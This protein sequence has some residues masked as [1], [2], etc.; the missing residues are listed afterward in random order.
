MNESNERRSA[1]VNKALTCMQILA[2]LDAAGPVR[3]PMTEDEFNQDDIYVYIA[4]TKELIT[5]WPSSSHKVQYA[6]RFGFR[7]DAGQTWAK[8]M[9]AK[10]LGLWRKS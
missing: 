5:S 8:G 3:M 9:A 2:E 4:A 6:R 7:I 1:A 10:H